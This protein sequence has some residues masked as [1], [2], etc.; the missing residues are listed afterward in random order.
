M[1]KEGRL[2]IANRRPEWIKRLECWEEESGLFPSSIRLAHERRFGEREMEFI[3]DSA[4]LK[5][6]IP[7]YC[8]VDNSKVIFDVYYVKNKPKGKVIGFE[9][10]FGEEQ[11][12]LDIELHKDLAEE[13]ARELFGDLTD[14]PTICEKPLSYNTRLSRLKLEYELITNE[15]INHL[16]AKDLLKRINL[17][18]GTIKELAREYRMIPE[19]SLKDIINKVLSSHP[20]KFKE[21]KEG[22]DKLAKFFIGQV[23]K[24]AKG[25]ADPKIITKYLKGGS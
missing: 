15:K 3:I 12:K 1:N 2:I 18:E 8:L 4:S 14:N 23:M 21:Y 9:S 10:K 7:Y 5:S 6:G 16:A 25:R 24:Q 19:G 20:E 22:K 13:W 11:L 17:K